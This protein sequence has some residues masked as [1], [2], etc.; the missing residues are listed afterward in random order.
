MTNR[1]T[2]VAVGLVAA[3]TAIAGCGSGS[4]PNPGLNQTPAPTSASVSATASAAATTSADPA[5][6]AVLGAYKSYTK[7][8]IGMYDKATFDGDLMKYAYG[9]EVQTQTDAIK[10]LRTSLISFTGAPNTNPA[11]VSVT[12]TTAQ[13]HDCFGSSTWL[14]V[15][16]GGADK[17]KTAVAPGSTV[18]AH[19]LT[20]TLTKRP[21]GNWYVTQTTTDTASTC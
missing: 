15:Y 16:F 21:D 11:V 13:V 4:K 9:Q 8:K 7:V 10:T 18:S 14:P 17:G 12:G 6:E 20:A 1:R 5:S 3:V 19:P 2:A